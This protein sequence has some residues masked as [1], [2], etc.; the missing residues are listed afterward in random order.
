MP[1]LHADDSFMK[2][3]KDEILHAEIIHRDQQLNGNN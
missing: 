2:K 3:P 1:L